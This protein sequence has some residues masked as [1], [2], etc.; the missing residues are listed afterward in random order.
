MTHVLFSALPDELGLYGKPMARNAQIWSTDFHSLLDGP[1]ATSQELAAAIAAVKQGGLF[2][3]RFQYPAMQLGHHAV[4]WQ[5]PLVAYLDPHTQR[6]SLLPENLLGYLTAYDTRDL[7]LGGSRRALAAR[8]ATRAASC[9]RGAPNREQG[10][11][12]APGVAKRAQAARCPAAPREEPPSALISLALCSAP[13][14]TR[15]W[16]SGSTPCRVD[17]ALPRPGDAWQTSSER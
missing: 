13:P 12:P 8:L 3:Y 11:V 10:E 16:T 2:G 1:A 9:G 4:Y 6:A 14:S 5:R 15:A 17:P 7:R